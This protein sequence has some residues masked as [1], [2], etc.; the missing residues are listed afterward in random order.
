ME[1]LIKKSINDHKGTLAFLEENVGLVKEMAML[2]I[3]TIK[4]GG[5]VL[6]FGN[7][8]SAADSQHLAAELV[9]RFK[10]NRPALA[11]IALTTDTSILTAIGNDFGFDAIFERQIEAL[12]KEGDLAVGLSTSGN[13]L[14]V[15]KAF[16]IAKE[17]KIRTISFLGNSGG[18]IKDIT[19]ISLVVPSAD[20]ARIQEIHSLTG[21]IICELV[22]NEL[23]S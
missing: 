7:G 20:T 16:N 19:D 17:K 21:H 3:S 18:K 5:K 14:N 2:F 10:K 4:S 9:G 11:S 23:F 22:E 1:D 13:S 6:F 8:G 12:G 15:I